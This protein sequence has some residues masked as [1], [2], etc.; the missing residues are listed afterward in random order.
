MHDFMFLPESVTLYT[1][2]GK[3]G[4]IKTVVIREGRALEKAERC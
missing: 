4:K 3:L 2:L 1:P